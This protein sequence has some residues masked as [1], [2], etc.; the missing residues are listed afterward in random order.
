MFFLTKQ[1]EE[2][3]IMMSY[4]DGYEDGY[5]AAKFAIATEALERANK[6]LEGLEDEDRRLEQVFKWAYNMGAQDMMAKHGIIEIYDI[7]EDFDDNDI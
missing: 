3:L 7:A 2:D 1:M 6:A 4:N 5:K